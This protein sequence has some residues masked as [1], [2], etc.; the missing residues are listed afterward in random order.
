L[1]LPLL[2]IFLGNAEWLY[3]VSR[4]GEEFGNSGHT[5]LVTSSA[6]VENKRERERE[7]QK[8]NERG[9]EQTVLSLPLQLIFLGNSEWLHLP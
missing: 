7:R 3:L 2:L 1:S 9:R 6:Y 8:K 4:E 5:R